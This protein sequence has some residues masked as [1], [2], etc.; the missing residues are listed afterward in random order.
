MITMGIAFAAGI[1]YWLGFYK[2]AFWILTYAIVYGGLGV[3]RGDIQARALYRGDA[4][5]TTVVLIPVT[6]HIGSLAG[7]F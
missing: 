4:G 5:I 6:W 7:Y 1:F 3:L 2:L